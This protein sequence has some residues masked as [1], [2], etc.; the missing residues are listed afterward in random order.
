MHAAA[1]A[2]ARVDPRRGLGRAEGERRGRPVQLGELP[3]ALLALAQVAL[4]GLGLVGVERV[5]RVGGGQ[6]VE[7]HEISVPGSPSCSRRLDSPVNILLLIV[8]RGCPSLSASSDWLKP[9]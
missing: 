1:A 5:E 8:P 7:V 2:A 4:V 3:A 9:P 6:V